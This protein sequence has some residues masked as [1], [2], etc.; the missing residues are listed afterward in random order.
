MSNLAKE[1]YDLAIYGEGPEK[2][3]LETYIKQLGLSNNV[4]LAG[5]KENVLELINNASMFVMSSDYE[6]MPN[7]LIEAM[8]MGMPVI[9]TDCPSG[10]PKQIINSTNGI[11][12]PVGDSEKLSQAMRLLTNEKLATEMA[13]EAY[14]IRKELT[15]ESIFEKWI[16]FLIARGKND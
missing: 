1:G 13:N 8:C 11:L 14:K 9:S 6:G 2:N 15:D 5:R 10:G 4:T 3:H 12:V 7:A 16:Q